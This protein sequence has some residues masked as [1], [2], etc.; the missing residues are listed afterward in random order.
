MLIALPKGPATSNDKDSD[1]GISPTASFKKFV[2]SDVPILLSSEGNN[3]ILRA[4][5]SEL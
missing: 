5:F 2:M 4:A 1:P 3:I